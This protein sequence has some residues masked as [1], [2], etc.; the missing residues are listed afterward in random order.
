[1]PAFADAH[2][3]VFD[4]GRG[5]LWAVPAAGGAARR[6]ADAPGDQWRAGRGRQDGEVIFVGS[7]GV[8][9]LDA[10]SG[11]TAP[12]GIDAFTAAASDAAMFYG[13]TDVAEIWRRAGGE[14]ARLVALPDGLWQ[15]A[16][17]ASGDGRRLAIT[18]H[19]QRSR[20]TVCVVDLD[21]TGAARPLDCLDRDDVILGRA[22]LTH[23]GATLYYQTR[24]GIRRRRLASGADELWLPGAYAYGGID[25]TRDGRTLVYAD[26]H[27]GDLVIAPI[28]APDRPALR[29]AGSWADVA[30]DGRWVHVRWNPD[31][32]HELVEH[33]LDG[34]RRVLVTGLGSL[35]HPQYDLT[36]RVV[37]F[38][39]SGAEGGIWTVDVRA[40]P[41]QR[42]TTRDGD[43][44]PV[45]TSDGKVAFTR[46]DEHKRP[47]LVLADPADGVL[48]DATRVAAHPLPRHTMA[49]VRAT[50]ELLL[51]GSDA[52]E[53]FAWN[54]ATR[55]ERRVPIAGL[56]PIAV[57]SPDGRRLAILSGEGVAEVPYPAGV[58]TRPSPRWAPPPGATAERPTW[59][60]EGRLHVAYRP[61]VGDVYAVAIEP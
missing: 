8:T 6:V 53:L 13:R 44:N 12:L 2:T 57:P 10:A 59:D 18:T 16:L 22:A 49:A 58:R 29:E 21:A 48:D 56:P 47:N 61:W 51:T 52:S 24:G 60:A 28:D 26:T 7:A 30:P 40:Y 1:M 31:G 34:A 5:D 15:Y 37:V 41:P 38:E 43:S 27:P 46:W 32:S 39:V 35:Q 55:R 14:D 33:L 42:L 11:Q 25:V 17:A 23:D 20:T 50:G 45:W 4:D 54:P 9:A 36:G 19:A 3:V